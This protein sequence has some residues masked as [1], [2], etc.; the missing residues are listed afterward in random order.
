MVDPSSEEEIAAALQRLA[1][2]GSARRLSAA[3][4]E[5]AAGFSWGRA[6]RETLEVLAG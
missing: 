6:A 1:E 3:G 2:P 4:R 5:R